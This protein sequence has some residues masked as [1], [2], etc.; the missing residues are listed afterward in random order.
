MTRSQPL[1]SVIVPTRDRPAQLRACLESLAHLDYPHD[2]FEVLVVDD[3]G[4]VPLDSIVES[5][6]TTIDVTLLRQDWA[7]PAAARNLGA[8]R[9]RGAL[10]AFTDDDC[11]PRPD[12]LRRLADRHGVNP[13]DATGGLTVNALLA[14]PYSN[15]AQLI[16][17]AGYAQRNYES[18]PFPF[19]TA[20][21]LAVPA[22]GFRE[23]GGFDA[24]YLTSEDREFCARWA[25]C[26][27]HIAYEPA[28]VVKHHH[29]LT[30][31]QFCRLYFAYGR[32]AFRFRRDQARQRRPV[33][34]EPAFYL[35]T[36]PRH[37]LAAGRSPLERLALL[38]L[39]A[40]WH[41]ANASGFVWEWI[42]TGMR[43]PELEA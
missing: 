2:R 39:L 3:G 6:R 15:A 40:P 4:A 38:T 12:W 22:V 10:L 13:H 33:P 24:R 29:P 37:A 27:R 34:I 31:W 36:L 18:S 17:D 20:N 41:L 1:C 11:A 43:G 21:N 26:G 8:A 9:A 30:F 35:R 32:G 42:R 16:I 25:W 19:F 5:V 14:N 7:G 23:V 28:A